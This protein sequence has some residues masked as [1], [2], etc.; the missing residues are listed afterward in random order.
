MVSDEHPTELD[1]AFLASYAEVRDGALTAVSASY[2]HLQVASFPGAHNL[3][4][5]GRI[6]CSPTADVELSIS[7]TAPG[8]IYQFDADY[9]LEAETYG[10]Q[11]YG[12]PPRVGLLFAVGG[13]IPLVAPGDYT[14]NV[15]LNGESQR[16]LLFN[17]A[18]A[19][20]AG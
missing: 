2:T 4:V 11:V 17:V 20:A 16:E 5:A 18:Q 9:P 8:G 3:F 13:P 7:V 15:L 12:D 10:A 19:E 6:R 14:V 1:Y